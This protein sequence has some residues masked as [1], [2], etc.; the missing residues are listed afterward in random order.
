M[1]EIGLVQGGDSDGVGAVAV[2][3]DAEVGEDVGSFVGGLEALEG[4]V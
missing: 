4:D 2:C 1:S 3:V